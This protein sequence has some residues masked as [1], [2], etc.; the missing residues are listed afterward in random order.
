M[1]G[2][3]R[4]RSRYSLAGVSAIAILVLGTPV[5][6]QDNQAIQAQI[7][8]LQSQINSLQR[9]V[10][11]ANVAAA[12]AQKSS[13]DDLDLKVKWRGAPEF[14]SADGKFKMK[15]RGRLNAD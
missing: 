1:T 13:G 10:E 14:S 9:Q 11:Q 2:G 8:A 5:D 4:D 12:A 3:L 15:L 7:K 6:A